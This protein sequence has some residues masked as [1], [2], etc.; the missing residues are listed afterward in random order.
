MLT[1]AK[2]CPL[3]RNAPWGCRRW[4]LGMK[5]G[6]TSPDGHP[7]TVSVYR[8]F[9]HISMM[10]HYSH[11]DVLLWYKNV[12]ATWQ[13]VHILLLRPIVTP[14]QLARTVN[15]YLGLQLWAIIVIAPSQTP[16]SGHS[17]RQTDQ[18]S[19]PSMGW[20]QWSEGWLSWP[21]PMVNPRGHI[22]A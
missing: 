22:R 13:T 1:P 19:C 6:I 17:A 4:C 2:L 18:P 16:Y 8:C 7:V 15:S 5:G 9:R 21:S 11:L 20:R 12:S 14:S 10:P 3:P